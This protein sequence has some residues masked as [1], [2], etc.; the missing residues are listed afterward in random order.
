MFT[1]SFM[2]RALVGGVLVALVCSVFSFFVNVRRLAFAG[3]GIAHAAFGGV[4]IGIL[5]GL[6]TMI[7]AGA[8]CVLVALGI[9]WF[10]KKGHIHEDTVI[11]ILYSASMALGVVL[12]A[13]AHAYNVDLMS[14]LFG[15]VLALTW[16]DVIVLAIVSVLSIA[17]AVLF[18][19]ELIFTVFD[20]ETASASGIHASF[21]Y[22]GLLVTIALVIVVSIKLI[23]IILVSA[24]LVIPGAVGMQLSRNYRGV[25]AVSMASALCSVVLGLVFSFRYNLASGA[26]IVL[27]LF[28]IFIIAL[29]LSPRRSYM[30]ALV[31][32]LKNRVGARELEVQGGRTSI[33][34]RLSPARQ[35]RRRGRR[36]RPL[37]TKEVAQEHRSKLEERVSDART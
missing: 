26:S 11:G 7:A 18:F 32:A 10:S 34:S 2:V 36:E 25:I 29:S 14:Y 5:A 12:I 33:W 8:F 20:E 6:N 24:L 28:G 30:A 9:G 1:H 19:K 35:G 17:F 16:G 31:D 23:G 13:A 21:A 27:T 15:S 37:L 4:A 3:E 22:Y